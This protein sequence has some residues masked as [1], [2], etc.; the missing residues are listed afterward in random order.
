MFNETGLMPDKELLKDSGTYTI[1]YCCQD[2]VFSEDRD[3]A[4][5]LARRF[6]FKAGEKK[7]FFK[8]T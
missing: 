8:V 2:A 1:G 6:Q 7:I 4:Q 5:H 3:F